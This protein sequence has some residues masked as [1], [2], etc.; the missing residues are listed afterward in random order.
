MTCA[1]PRAQCCACVDFWVKLAPGGGSRERETGHSLGT[2]LAW[3]QTQHNIGRQEIW[4]A[5]GVWILYIKAILKKS[6]GLLVYPLSYE[7]KF[8]F[9]FILNI[10]GLN[11]NK[12]TS[13]TSMMQ[14][15]S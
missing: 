7:C 10:E 11:T 1:W 9:S 6:N 15:A 14:K 12:P 8:I 5:P 2:G 3:L 4:G 13:P